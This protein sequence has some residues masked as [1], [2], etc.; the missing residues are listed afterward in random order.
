MMVSSKHASVVAT[1]LD[2]E[3]RKRPSADHTRWRGLLSV[4]PPLACRPGIESER[5]SMRHRLLLRRVGGAEEGGGGGISWRSVS[6][7]SEAA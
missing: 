7:L 3:R 5:G 4:S 2:D 1:N 6:R